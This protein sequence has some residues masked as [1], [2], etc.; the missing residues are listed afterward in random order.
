MAG[1]RYY[2]IPADVRLSLPATTQDDEK[3]F[4]FQPKMEMPG[5][6]RQ[7]KRALARQ[8]QR[9]QACAKLRRLML[10]IARLCGGCFGGGAGGVSDPRARPKR[11][12]DDDEESQRPSDSSP[13]VYGRGSVVQIS[14]DRTS[15]AFMDRV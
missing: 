8:A 14:A 11:Q 2:H 4:E 7:M 3:R 9:G 15:D 5:T 6:R 13:V 12:I 10:V 1:P